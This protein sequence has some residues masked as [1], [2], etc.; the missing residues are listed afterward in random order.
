V[1]EVRIR[2][3]GEDDAAAIE[4]VLRATGQD[5]DWGGASPAYLRHLGR[6]GQVLVAERAGVVAG[7]GAAQRIGSGPASVVMLCDLFVDPAV[8]GAGIGRALLTRL[9]A[10][11]PRRMTFSSL[12]SHA[13]PLYASFGL[14]AWW[15]QLYLRGDA[16]LLPRP[17]GWAVTV[18]GAADVG[19]IELAWT[20]ADR[21]ADHA[22]WAGQPGA[23][24]VL[25]RSPGGDVVAAGTVRCE[26]RDRGPVHL[27]LSPAA[28]DETAAAAVLAVLVSLDDDAAG[29]SESG[30]ALAYLPAPH[31][32]A[33]A[34]L[35]AGWRI[36][37]FDL[38]MGSE[39]GLL[40]PRRAVPSP[41]QA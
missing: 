2:L 28:D 25:A 26:G 32:A 38:F 10:D 27:A 7:F 39:P 16:R 15:P 3:A 13:M 19:A 31:P 17:A 12:H 24:P 29:Q 5:D 21:T 1:D 4:A 36:G 40:D 35:A 23:V 11:A 41:G 33:R 34:L 37:E 18:A 8:H 20:G 9:W 6:H 30:M 22:A 14:D